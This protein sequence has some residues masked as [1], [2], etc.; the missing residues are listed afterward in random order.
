MKKKKIL[1][2]LGLF[3][4][5]GLTLASCDAIIDSS[6][7]NDE[8]TTDTSDSTS[9]TDTSDSSSTTDTSDSTSTTDTSDSSSTTDTSDSSS[10]SDTSDSSST[11]D[12]SDSSS[13]TDTSDSSSTTDTSDS[14]STTDTS[15]S[16]STTDTS[17]SSSTTDDDSDDTYTVDTT[18]A[19]SEE[20][21]VDNLTITVVENTDLGTGSY[22]VNDNIITILSAGEYTLTG[23]LSEGSVEVYAEDAEVIINL[24]NATIKSTT[25]A[26]INVITAS[27]VEISAKKDSENNIYD[28]RTTADDDDPTAA[29]YAAD[30]DLKIKGKGTLNV[31]GNYNNGIHAKDDLTVKNLTL[32]VKA[33]NNALKGNDSVEI[34]SATA[35][36][37]STGGDGIKT[38]N[39]DVSSKGNQKGYVTITGLATVT[40]YA[41][42]DGIDA[43][44][45]A[46][47]LADDDGN[48]PTVN[49][50][51]SS[52][53]EYSGEVASTTE[54]SSVLYVRMSSSYY[55]T[56]KNYDLYAYCYST[57]DSSVYEWIPLNYYT[58][59]SGSFGQ[60]YYYYKGTV[61]VSN[62]TSIRLYMFTDGTI[63]STSSYTAA[64]E[65]QN[66]NTTKD[67]LQIKKISGTKITY[68]WGNYS[69]TTST[70]TVP[71]G[72]SGM[73]Q[74]NTDKTEYSTK[75]IKAANDINISAGTIT[76]YAY[77]DG[78]HAQEGNTLGDEDDTTDD[79]TSTGCITISGGTITITSKDDGVHADATLTISGGNVTVT[80]A[81]E[82]LEGNKIV[83][84]GG[85]HN[86]YGTDD[87]INAQS[88]IVISGGT[89]QVLVASGD[90]DAID[91]NGTYTQTGGVVI[92]MNMQASGTAS[93]LDCDSTVKISG[94]TFLGFG[95]IESTPSLSGVSKTTKSASMSAG[96]Y[97]LTKDGTTLASFTLKASYSSFTLIGA[98]GSYTVGS[99]S[100]T[101]S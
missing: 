2:L 17:D 37:I 16:T 75:G 66:I 41:C 83:I 5:F 58:Y 57:S 22:V 78:L 3:A 20:S 36:I 10:T 14:S 89:L 62:Y 87:G 86:V 21:T 12:T 93:I 69:T 11:T 53:S 31:Y 96:T 79:V 48:E 74:G 99:T 45:N 71:G 63:P 19:T 59:V 88:A 39:S 95:N 94:G 47:I 4:I 80:T 56:Y 68:D 90:T 82:G 100:V 70:S 25:T 33:V 26:P 13:T 91:S 55:S 27:D 7:S 34:D 9:T 8:T 54:S 1:G 51:T 49:I 65:G 30:G 28:N 15:D 60:T 38:T 6:V 97:S 46:E 44:Y 42:C 50:Y 84:S 92:A 18:N 29:I 64:S 43:A 35:T 52:Y 67:L 85:T 76:I 73:D 81:Y 32:Y 101:L 61:D 72:M 98:S 24:E 23:E 77:D 40:V